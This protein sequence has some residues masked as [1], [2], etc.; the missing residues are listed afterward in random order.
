MEIPKLDFEAAIREITSFIKRVVE[1]AGSKGV[2]LGLS[3]G[4]DSSVVAALCAKALGGERCL[5]VIMPAGFTP[6][7]DVED[8]ER[9]ARSLGIRTAR[10]DIDTVSDAFFKT[11]KVD[12]KDPRCKIPAAN[13]RARIRMAILYYYANLNNLLV[14]GTGDKSERLIGYFTKYGDGGVDFAPIAHLYKAQ[15]REL[16]KHLGL[17]EKVVNK[18]SSPQLYPG[19][20]ATDEIPTDYGLLDQILVGL[21]NLK[22]PPR[23]VSEQTGAPLKTVLEVLSRFNATK[24]KRALPPMLEE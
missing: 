1:E 21:F 19:H 9:L 20:K 17:P 15:V 24:H 8:A 23:K 4:V 13:L 11:L 10:A 12:L 22:L 18:P 14:A 16:G 3:G 7:E 6:K 2:V 5:G